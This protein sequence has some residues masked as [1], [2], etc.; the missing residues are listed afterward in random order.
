MAK[1]P[2]IMR[3]T[4]KRFAA[5]ALRRASSSAFSDWAISG[6]SVRSVLIRSRSS[7]EHDAQDGGQAQRAGRQGAGPAVPHAFGWRLVLLG[8]CHAVD[9]SPQ[10]LDRL[11]LREQRVT[12]TE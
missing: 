6:S 7:R 3:R 8:I 5:R 9:E 11:G 12:V 1:S 2:P 4:S 10:I